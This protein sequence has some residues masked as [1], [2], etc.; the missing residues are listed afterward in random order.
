VYFNRHVYFGGDS[1]RASFGFSRLTPDYFDYLFMNKTEIAEVLRQEVG[2]LEVAIKKLQ[3]RCDGLKQFVIDLDEEIEVAKGQQQH[4]SPLMENSKFRTM[5]D[6]V[7][8][9]KPKRPKTK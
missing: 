6:S 8:G 3:T 5:V 9:E 7:F 1:Q 4:S 2:E